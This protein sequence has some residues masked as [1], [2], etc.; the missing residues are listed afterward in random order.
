[1]VKKIC[2]LCMC[3]VIILIMSIFYTKSVADDLYNNI[4]RLHIIANSDSDYD[5][6]IKYNIRNELIKNSEYLKNEKFSSGAVKEIASGVLKDKC[7]NYEAYCVYGDF[8]FPLKKYENIVLPSGVYKGIKVILGK[9]E[10]RN[11]WCVISPPM[12]FTENALGLADTDTLNKKLS[13]ETLEVISDKN[14]INYKFKIVEVISEMK[15][16]LMK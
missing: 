12:C 3:C 2:C 13:N 9:G 7:V 8:Y 1:M 5:Q 15:N 11:W 4:V 14:G 16:K 6:Q 10:G